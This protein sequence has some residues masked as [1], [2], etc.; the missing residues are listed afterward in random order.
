VHSTSL[1]HTGDIDYDF[2]VAVF[3]DDDYCEV[4]NLVGMTNLKVN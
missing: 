4:G 2:V 1:V 3:D